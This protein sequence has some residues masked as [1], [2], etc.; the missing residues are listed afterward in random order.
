MANSSS[1]STHYVYML[2]CADETYYVGITHSL[3]KRMSEHQ[4]G[5]LSGYTSTR[6][7]VAL[8]WSESVQTEHQAAILE[9][10]IKGW[11]RAKKE[12]LIRGDLAALHDIVKRERKRRERRTRS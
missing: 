7:P 2:R 5:E 6:R 4:S 11:T 3:Q 10:Q 8:V 9:R 1:S 12:S